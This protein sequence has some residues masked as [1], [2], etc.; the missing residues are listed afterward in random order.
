M[1]SQLQPAYNYNIHD[2]RLY[3]ILLREYECTKRCSHLSMCVFF[4]VCL[5]SRASC[6]QQPRRMFVMNVLV[7]VARE[8]VKIYVLLPTK[9]HDREVHVL[10]SRC[11]CRLQCRSH[12]KDMKILI[13]KRSRC[14]VTIFAAEPHN[15][16][17][18]NFGSTFI[19]FQAPSWSH[20][21]ATFLG[22]LSHYVHFV[23]HRH[24]ARSLQTQ[25]L[26][27]PGSAECGK[28]YYLISSRCAS[29][30][31]RLSS[32]SESYIF[33]PLMLCSSWRMVFGF[34]L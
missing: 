24:E 12:I 19:S 6:K 8:V 15:N 7:P 1:R 30:V 23:T 5:L 11:L 20:K 26:C 31:A 9:S 22:F 32:V 2:S 17:A 4:W 27:A 25:N 13:M 16:T 21:A 29:I 33:H 14:D 28:E 18:L 3:S 10:R 34:K